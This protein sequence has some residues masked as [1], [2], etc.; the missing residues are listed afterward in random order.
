MV[1]GETPDKKHAC[2]DC[3]FCQWCSDERCGLCLKRTP[4]KKRKLSL[5]EQIALYEAVN[6]GERGEEQ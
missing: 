5:Q 6:N 1:N 4:A 2:P 3:G